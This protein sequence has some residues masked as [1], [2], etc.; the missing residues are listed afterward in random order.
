[1]RKKEGLN[2]IAGVE[3][4]LQILEVNSAKDYLLLRMQ[5]LMRGN[6]LSLLL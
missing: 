3:F 1:M 4:V 6:A 2:L 5:D